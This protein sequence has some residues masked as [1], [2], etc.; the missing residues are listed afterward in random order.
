MCG[1]E[2][3]AEAGPEG[4]GFGRV[5]LRIAPAPFCVVARWS[6]IRFATLSTY[7]S[8]NVTVTTIVKSDG[9][10]ENDASVTHTICE[11][12][13]VSPRP[14]LIASPRR[15][16]GIPACVS[17]SDLIGFATAAR[18]WRACS[19]RSLSVF[20]SGDHTTRRTYPNLRIDAGDST[21]AWILLNCGLRWPFLSFFVGAFLR[22][23]IVTADAK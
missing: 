6:W 5:F 10:S 15:R 16:N 18:Y 9:E 1:F 14:S 22:P 4:F 7:G 3:R 21:L 12:S 20:A 19:T 11:R 13:A 2:S 8:S 17:V 23:R